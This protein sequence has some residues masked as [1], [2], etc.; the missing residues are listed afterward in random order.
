MRNYPAL[1][2]DVITSRLIDLNVGKASLLVKTYIDKTCLRPKTFLTIIYVSFEVIL[3]NIFSQIFLRS[4]RF[5]KGIY[6][7]SAI[8][9]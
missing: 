2:P 8:I 9:F 1:L 3:R 7:L 4:N 5:Y 6:F